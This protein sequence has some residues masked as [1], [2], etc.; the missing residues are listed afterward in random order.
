MR[1]AV[2]AD[3]HHR[4]DPSRAASLLTGLQAL[5]RRGHAVMLAISRGEGSEQLDRLPSGP[6]PGDGLT[7]L[8]LPSLPWG[9]GR[10]WPAIPTGI[11]ALRCRAWA[12]DILHS[13][14]ALGAGLE[15][16]AT[17][18]IVGAPLIST[19]RDPI[20]TRPHR[21]LAS[22]KAPTPVALR[23]VRWYYRQC[24]L[25]TTPSERIVAA[26]R[27]SGL[28]VPVR[29]VSDPLPLD[30][31]P[32]VGRPI[33]DK[34]RR[35]LRR[36]ALIHVG[37]LT[38]VQRVDDIIRAI[39]SLITRIPAVSLTLV[40]TGPAE[41]A[42][43][44]LAERLQVTTHVRFVGELGRPRL[45]DAYA[46]SDAFVSLSTAET[47]H[48]ATIEAMAAGLPAIGART[49]ALSE[50]VDASRGM[51][52]EAG[53]TAALVASILALHREPSRA[54]ALGAAG[55]AYAA[56]FGPEPIAA[57]WEAIYG[58]VLSKSRRRRAT[59]ATRASPHPT[60]PLP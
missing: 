15:G 47:T 12:P 24:D 38:A 57:E 30:P 11:A 46:A 59:K 9:A 23:Y 58:E 26:V 27:E 50:C 20:E 54:A 5:A 17:A 7:L 29:V 36:F 32:S 43:R 21:G 31:W 2:F 8:R 39:P 40:G 25:V 10:H 52:V 49:P 28:R 42:L 34:P 4:Q 1:I 48:L 33:E 14:D 16:L 35:G 18:R 19:L 51:L 56:R 44:T 55:R 60:S 22:V 3:W 45:L 53:N 13:Q 41:P 37:R 6:E